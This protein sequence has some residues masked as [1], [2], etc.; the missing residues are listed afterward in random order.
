[1]EAYGLCACGMLSRYSYRF[2]PDGTIAGMKDGRWSVWKGRR[3]RRSWWR[4]LLSNFGLN[5]A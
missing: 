5:S 3:V 1:M 2:L 4:R